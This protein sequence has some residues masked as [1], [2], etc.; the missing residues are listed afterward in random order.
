MTTGQDGRGIRGI[1]SCGYFCTF[2]FCTQLL[3]CERRPF[4]LSSVTMDGIFDGR[5]QIFLVQRTSFRLFVEELRGLFKWKSHTTHWIS[6]GTL[7]WWHKSV[8]VR[9]SCGVWVWL[10]GLVPTECPLIQKT[11]LLDVAVDR[12]LLLSQKNNRQT[13]EQ[14]MQSFCEYIPNGLG[15]LYI[16]YFQLVRDNSFNICIIIILKH[17]IKIVYKTF[18]NF[19][20]IGSDWSI[21]FLL[22]LFLN[23]NE[24]RKA[25][26]WC[27]N[28]CQK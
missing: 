18:L 12:L 14:Q 19:V 9:S 26:L 13:T 11:T 23:E 25:V 6:P 8:C 4:L 28:S 16:I 17:R 2:L 22:I 27:L 15:K 10:E 24:Y 1:F 7:E 3:K 21:V 20:E 5:R